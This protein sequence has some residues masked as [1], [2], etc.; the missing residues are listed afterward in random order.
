MQNG[1]SVSLATIL[2]NTKLSAFAAASSQDCNFQ[3]DK[4]IAICDTTEFVLHDNNENLELS[5]A[6][7]G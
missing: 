1:G 7:L 2:F 4:F 3:S 6:T 5:L